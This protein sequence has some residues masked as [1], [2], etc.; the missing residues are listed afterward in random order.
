MN[1]NRMQKNKMEKFNLELHTN[2]E[3]NNNCVFCSLRKI[4]KKA[5]KK[6]LNNINKK[7]IYNLLKEKRKI[8]NSVTFLGGE[9]TIIKDFL[10]FVKFA[11]NKNYYVSAATNGRMLSNM[12]FCK[13]LIDTKIDNLIISIHGQNEAIGDCLANCPGSFSQTI[14]GMDNLKRLNKTFSTN[15]VINKINYKD[16][17]KIIIFLKKYSPEKIRLTFPDP[18]GV[19]RNYPSKEYGAIKNF[20][21]IIPT[22]KEVFPYLIT[23]LKLGKKLKLNVETT[24]IPFCIMGKYKEYMEETQYTRNGIIITHVLKD[25]K[26]AKGHINDK[27]KIKK[28]KLCEYENVC[29]GIWKEYLKKYG[30]EEFFP[31]RK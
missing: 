8:C 22:Y 17:S 16:L 10:N 18:R 1:L 28:C 15:T 4:H 27:S 30:D 11:K 23:A 20:Y 13:K 26:I 3:C 7:N 14:R 25:I 2:L 29:E 9:P 12:I 24:D 19:P 21:Q 31:I 6:G 5:S